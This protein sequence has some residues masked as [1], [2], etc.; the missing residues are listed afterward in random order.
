VRLA[1]GDLALDGWPGTRVCGACVPCAGTLTQKLQIMNTKMKVLL[2][3]ISLAAFQ[4]IPGN[5]TAQ[6]GGPDLFP[7]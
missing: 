6:L 3:A 5:P 7:N 1:S 2:I 4:Q